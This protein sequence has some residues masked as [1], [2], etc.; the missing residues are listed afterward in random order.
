MTAPCRW[1]MC[2]FE[3]TKT[4]KS[5]VIEDIYNI[6]HNQ[7]MGHLMFLHIQTYGRIFY[8]W[9]NIQKRETFASD[10]QVT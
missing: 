9:T 2:K 5:V 10:S 4:T 1:N 3:N 6:F 7:I 8:L